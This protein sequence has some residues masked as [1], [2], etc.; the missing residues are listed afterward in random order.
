[1]I[2]MCNLLRLKI[3]KIVKPDQT[4]LAKP[5]NMVIHY[6]V[7]RIRLQCMHIC[8]CKLWATVEMSVHKQ[9]PPLINI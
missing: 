3:K 2:P 5:K 1:M 8:K 4:H 9:T 6:G 7:C